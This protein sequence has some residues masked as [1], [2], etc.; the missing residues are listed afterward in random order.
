MSQND[1]DLKRIYISND[2]FFPQIIQ[3]INEGH[4]V[5][6]NLRGYSMRPFLENERDKAL[7]QRPD[8][9]ETGMPVLA[10]ISKGRYVLHRIIRIDGD[11]VTL[12]GDGNYIPEHCT[13]ADIKAV[14]IA[15]YRKGSSKPDS[16]YGR[17][18]EIYSRLWTLLYPIRRYLLFIYRII[19]KIKK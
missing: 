7:L 11:K 18:W 19:L 2:I 13:L 15:F 4:T 12:L 14:A 17:K 1:N 5:T 3:Q 8:K 16:I 6:L 10:E 9:I